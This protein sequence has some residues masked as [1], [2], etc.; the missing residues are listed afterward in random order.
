MYTYIY[1]YIYKR[2][3]ISQVAES[4]AKET[5]LLC[6]D[7]FQVTDICD[8]MILSKLFAVLWSKGTV[9]IATSNRPPSDLY[10]DGLNRS[11]FIPFITQLERE[12]IVKE[13]ASDKDY[14]YLLLFVC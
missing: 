3:A 14:R 5:K 8:A 13:I 1:I 11:Y 10:K 12:C 9:L 7:E 4:I 2:D 6:F